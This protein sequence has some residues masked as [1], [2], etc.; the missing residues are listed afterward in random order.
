MLP[1]SCSVV[2]HRRH[3]RTHLPSA[4]FFFGFNFTTFDIICGLLLNRCNMESICQAESGSL[5]HCYRFFLVLLGGI[6]LKLYIC[7]TK[8]LNS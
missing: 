3:A 2:D 7:L 5:T 8:A 6:S 1:C 4:I